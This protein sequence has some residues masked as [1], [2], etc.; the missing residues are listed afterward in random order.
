MCLIIFFNEV[1]IWALLFARLACRN[2]EA[3][4][5]ANIGGQAPSNQTCLPFQFGGQVADRKFWGALFPASRRG[6]C[7]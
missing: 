7:Y 1:A 3:G 2:G 6:K 4:N 5:S